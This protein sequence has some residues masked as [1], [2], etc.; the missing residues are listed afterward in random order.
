MEIQTLPMHYFIIDLQL[1][2]PLSNIGTLTHLQSPHRDWIK[3]T[4]LNKPAVRETY[5][6]ESIAIDRQTV[7]YRI[8]SVALHPHSF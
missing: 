1:R 6:S 5:W 2:M 4:L 8:S 3:T 7:I